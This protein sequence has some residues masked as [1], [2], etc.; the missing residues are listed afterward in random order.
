M[1]CLKPPWLHNGKRVR[2]E[3]GRRWVH[4]SGKTKDYAIVNCCVFDKHTSL[5]F[6]NTRLVVQSWFNVF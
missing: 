4:R 6:K 1:T 2:L 5:R 3:C